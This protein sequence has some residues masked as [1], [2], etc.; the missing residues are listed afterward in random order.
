MPPS[1]P[2]PYGVVYFAEPLYFVGEIRAGVGSPA[3]LAGQARLGDRLGHGQQI[4]QI[5]GRMPAGVVLA[6]PRRGGHMRA[7][8]Q[9][10]DRFER[11]QHLVFMA[12]DADFR[13]HHRLQL[14][15]NRKRILALAA[16][17]EGRHGPVLG[18]LD[19]LSVDAG[20]TV[21][22]GERRGVFP[23]A[24]AEDQQIGQRVAA[25]AVGAVQAGRALSPAANNPG[26]LLICESASTSMPPMT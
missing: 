1:S 13:L 2:L 15:L 21:F 11:L 6:V 16:P 26:T 25:Q 3:F 5:Q 23:G 14:V 19:L 10:V 22:S 20:G 18:V 17:L 7:L 12:H 24:L 9:P 4:L 8:A